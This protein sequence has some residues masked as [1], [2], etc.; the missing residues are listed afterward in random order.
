ML[1]FGAGSE[2][3]CRL[4]DNSRRVDSFG[5]PVGRQAKR[6][7]QVVAARGQ[8]QIHAGERLDAVYPVVEGA[9]VD[10]QLFGAVS[11]RRRSRPGRRRTFR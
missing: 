8:P 3:I 5:A 9:A 1:G 11:R 2:L 6:Q 7:V 4:F 10:V